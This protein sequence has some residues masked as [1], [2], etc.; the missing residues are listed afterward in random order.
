MAKW[1]YLRDDLSSLDVLDENLK[2]RGDAGWELVTIFRAIEPK[3]P[4]E[5]ILGPESWVLIFKQ[6]LP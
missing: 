4:D 1:R 5:N 2:E 3:K 6:P